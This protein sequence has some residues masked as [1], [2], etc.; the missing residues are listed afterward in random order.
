MAEERAQKM[1]IKMLFPLIFCI[2]PAL[3]VVILTPMIINIVEAL[4][5]VPPQA[6]QSIACGGCKA[7][8]CCVLSRPNTSSIGAPC[9]L[10]SLAFRAPQ[11][12]QHHLRRH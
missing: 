11:A 3:F 9:V 5:L 12:G 2:F 10:A 8:R 6:M 7:S 4:G 1:P